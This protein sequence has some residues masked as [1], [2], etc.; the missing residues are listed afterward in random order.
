MLRSIATAAVLVLVAPTLAAAQGSENRQQ[1]PAPAAAPHPG[2]APPG[3]APHF[4]PAPH[5][6]GAGVVPHPEGPPGRAVLVPHPGGPPLGGPPHPGGPPIGVAIGA[7]PGAPPGRFIFRGREFAG[8]HADPFVYPPGWTYRQW[9]VGAVLPPLF[10]VPN[11]Y[12]TDWAALGLEPPPPGFQWVRYG[13]DLLLV[14]LGDGQVA[15]V[16]Y[17]VFY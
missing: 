6:V 2:G 14:N 17:G 9:A 5:P 11:Y 7:H 1:H 8:V 15:D 3:G 4:V 16:A 12:Y 13:P 10:L